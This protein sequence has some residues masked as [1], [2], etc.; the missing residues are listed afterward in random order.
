MLDGRAGAE[1]DRLR[2]EEVL[3]CR[4]PSP[5]HGIQ[6]RLLLAN[7]LHERVPPP[8]ELGEAAGVDDAT[9]VGE[10]PFH[11]RHAEVAAAKGVELDDVLVPRCLLGDGDSVVSLE[12]K[13]AV[14]AAAH[15]GAGELLIEPPPPPPRPRQHTRANDRAIVERDA[16][17]R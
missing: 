4:L 12:A 5:V 1:N 3:L 10:S 7:A 2:G 14:S 15:E 11:T 9:D 17:A 13:V 16:R 8:L 6:R